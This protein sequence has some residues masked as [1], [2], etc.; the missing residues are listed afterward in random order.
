M[1]EGA[2]APKGVSSI[3][4]DDT[5]WPLALCTFRGTPCAEDVESWLADMGALYARGKRFVMLADVATNRHDLSHVRRIGEWAREHRAVIRATCA[6]AAVMVQ[7]PWQRFVISAFYLV[8]PPP[9]PMA[10]FDDSRSAAAWLRERAEEDGLPV[11]PYLER[12]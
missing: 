7:S 12:L 11:P 4:V 5:H 3:R 9:C 10:V 8:V 1:G 2:A 6:A